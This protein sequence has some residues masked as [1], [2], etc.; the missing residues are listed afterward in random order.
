[1]GRSRGLSVL[2]RRLRLDSTD[3]PGSCDNATKATKTRYKSDQ[4]NLNLL[5]CPEPKVKETKGI[6]CISQVPPHIP[7]EP[8][9]NPHPHPPPPRPGLECMF[10]TLNESELRAPPPSP[11][12]FPQSEGWAA[13]LRCSHLHTRPHTAST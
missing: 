6:G 11:S 9:L 13:E 1:M 12:L 7:P 2:T 5:Q 4:A 3:L 10:K 8:A